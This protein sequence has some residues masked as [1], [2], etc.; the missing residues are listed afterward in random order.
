MADE[1]RATQVGLEVLAQRSDP[2]VRATQ[3]GLEILAHI[4]PTITAISD[5]CLAVGQAL[6]IN[7]SDFHAVQGTGFV[8]F[9]GG[10]VAAITSWADAQIVCTVPVGTTR[11]VVTVTDSDGYTSDGYAYSM[12]PIISGLTSTCLRALDSITIFGFY[13]GAAQGTGSVD[14]A[15]GGSAIVSAWDDDQITV[16]VPV[17][18]I[19]GNVS[20]TND[21]GCVSN[22]FAYY[23]EPVINV[24]A[25]GSGV[26]LA[27]VSIIGES[28]YAVQGIGGVVIGALPATIVS[29]SDVQIDLLVPLLAP[30]VYNLFVVNSDGCFSDIVQFTVLGAGGRRTTPELPPV[31]DSISV[32]KLG[33]PPII[34]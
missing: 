20:V 12:H 18:T 34:G 5:A 10:G 24:L 17:G 13:F 22:N 8:S 1:V 21:D 3:V 25:P 11:G 27:P 19:K 28:F 32:T 4:K 6:T 31:A 23:T 2:E 29:W 15:G 7:G 14:F 26:P 33:Q 30:G 16:L 9:T